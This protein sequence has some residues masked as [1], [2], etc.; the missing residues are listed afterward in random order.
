[1]YTA[2][3]TGSP[4][5]DFYLSQ[6]GD[7]SKT[8]LQY[9]SA[10]NS[11]TLLGAPVLP[12]KLSLKPQI[13]PLLYPYLN[14]MSYFDDQ[15]YKN[16]N[17]YLGEFLFTNGSGWMYTIN[18]VFPN[19][20][21]ADSYLS[22]GDVLRLQYTLAYG[23]DIGGAGTMGG[24]AFSDDD[25]YPVANK[26]RLTA[27]LVSAGSAKGTGA[28]SN[29][30]TALQ[31]VN[32]TQSQVNSAY[33]ALQAVLRPAAS[34]SAVTAKPASTA[35]T[36]P[37]VTNSTKPAVTK[38]S[39]TD[40]ASTTA[41]KQG[42]TNSAGAAVPAA[43]ASVSAG[44][45]A[46]SNDP[47]AGSLPKKLYT[48]AEI[49]NIALG[50][51]AWKKLDNGSTQDGKLINSAYLEQAGSTTGD[52]YQIGMSRL[53]VADNYEGYLAVIKNTVQN[54]YKT[55]GKLSTAKA[56]EW[57]RI[58]LA[59]LAAGGNP[60]RLGAGEDGKP[61]NLIAD[62]TYNRGKTVSPG[63]QGINGW[64]WALITV[65]SM[66]YEIPDGAADTRESIIT[67]IIR[68][69]L[70]DGGFALS[71]SASD[72]D[73]T[74][75]AL[76]ALA[77]YYGSGKAYSYTQKITG[78]KVTKTVRQ[79]ADESLS[80]LSQMQTSDG[81][82]FSWGTKNAESTA[83]VITALCCLGL[84]PQRDA[85]F[86]KNGKTLPDG[87]MLYQMP[88]GGFTHSFTYDEENPTA[89]PGSANSM[90]G[91]Q[92]LCAL[93][94]LWRQMNGL[95]TLYD[96]RPEEGDDGRANSTPV[97]T[98]ADKQAAA[99]LPSPLT[100]EQYV[101]VVT[102][103][104]KLELTADFAG[105]DELQAQLNAAKTEI[106]ALQAEIDS[107]NAEIL[108]K[109]YPFDR[110]TLRDK[111]V[112]DG[113]A[114]RYAKLSDYD[115]AKVAHWEDVLKA[116]TKLNTLLRGLVLGGVLLIAVAAAAV[117][118]VLRIRRRKRAKG[119]AMEEL[120]AQYANEDE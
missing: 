58:A 10:V 43:S 15:D 112:A 27:L 88:D 17:G 45:P 2:F 60:T 113:I 26:D 119:S 81:D 41:P 6:V 57:H 70:P 19:V 79:I 36:K 108:D 11:R 33:T 78:K 80:C 23:A 84:D 31:T 104:E 94:A 77:P 106:E 114:A 72:A 62:G 16:A 28:Y 18:N 118:L 22:D 97:F 3:Y 103:L 116:Q 91:E 86:I 5:K 100:T 73:I 54:R 67:E 29:A 75:M 76:Q 120:A 50:I 52:W 39:V 82:F 13:P 4:S 24:G 102:L 59:L 83:Q 64:I 56:T 111:A 30:L 115:K 14:K 35:P 38:P 20:G 74:A 65:D 34:T 53:G 40:S 37:S 117:V 46:A 105:R 55:P 92:V 42:S 8:N 71:G 95:R 25:F 47:S 89:L 110:L 107:L 69:Q 1:G 68:Q 61:I 9:D 12:Q 87:I 66:R 32:S 7:G 21:F 98:D 48:S 93:A 44:V 96:F 51:I 63:R 99:D 49:R 101:A 85:R 90:A 109:L